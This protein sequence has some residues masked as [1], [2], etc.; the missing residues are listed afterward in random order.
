MR[1]TSITHRA[2]TAVLLVFS[3]SFALS[4]VAL[5]QVPTLPSDGGYRLAGPSCATF[6]AGGRAAT[7]FRAGNEFVLKGAQYPSNV[8][9]LVMFRQAP[10]AFE[11]A[12][13]KT[14]DAG[15]FTSEPTILRVP[16]DA[17]SGLASIRVASSG[18]SASCEMSL[19]AM[20]GATGARRA[21]KEPVSDQ[22]SPWLIVWATL[23][24]LGGGYL[25]FLRYR[26]YRADALERAMYGHGSPRPDPWS[27]HVPD[28]PP[29]R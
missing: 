18:G 26:R 5:A 2:K 28:S 25:M 1:P 14:N 13:F 7:D 10:L 6:D 16:A 23:V 17:S 20:P 11:L 24:A 3:I 29:E 21:A 27:P 12:R 8:L 9:V 4:G 15:E 22:V 19:T